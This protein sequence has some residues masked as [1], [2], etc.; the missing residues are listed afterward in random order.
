VE[1]TF[2]DLE[3]VVS[4]ECQRLVP[5]AFKNLTAHD[6]TAADCR[7]GRRSGN[8]PRPFAAGSAVMDFCAHPH[9]D[10]QNLVNGCTA[11]TS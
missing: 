3:A 5:D 10:T 2:A 11:V 7:L 1:A 4:P 6:E 8:R 9:R